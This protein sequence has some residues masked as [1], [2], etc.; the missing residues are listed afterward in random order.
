MSPYHQ[1]EECLDIWTRQRGSCKSNR[2]Q[3]FTLNKSRRSSLNHQ[4]T[5][6][7]MEISYE[8]N[9]WMGHIII[10]NYFFRIFMHQK[11]K[12]S[13]SCNHDR[14]IRNGYNPV[15]ITASTWTS[16]STNNM[17]VCK[18]AI[19]KKFVGAFYLFFL[20]DVR[21]SFQSGSRYFYRP[22]RPPIFFMK[23]W[24]SFLDFL[25]SHKGNL[26]AE[27]KCD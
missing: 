7:T 9:K 23:W 21:R 14:G 2:F 26:R 24:N 3:V 19:S 25:P 22:L 11:S 10:H 20:N 27:R 5:F 4:Q 6:Y 13:G 1:T 18:N 16:D 15:F 12:N 8:L 17:L